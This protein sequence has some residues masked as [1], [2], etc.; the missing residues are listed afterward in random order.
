MADTNMRLNLVMGMV[1]KLTAPIQKV[2]TQTTKAG[3]KIKATGAELKKLGAMSKDIEHFRKLKTES[4]QTSQ[5]LDKAQSRVSRLAAEM[6]AAE[7]PTAKMT[8]EFKAA[9]KKR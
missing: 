9:Q 7:K 5:A 6:Q 8:R 3:D 4:T 2:T 1:D